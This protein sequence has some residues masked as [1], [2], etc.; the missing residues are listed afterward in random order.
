MDPTPPSSLSSSFP[1]R[2]TPSSSTLWAHLIRNDSPLRPS[3]S[4]VSSAMQSMP[5][6]PL[7]K[8]GTSMR[9]L[10]LDTQTNFEN[11]SG[12]VDKLIDCVENA[13]SEVEYMKAMMQAERENAASEMIDLVNRCQRE[14]QKSIK[15]PAQGAQ[16]QSLHSD[17]LA[18]MELVCSRLESIDESHKANNK[19]LHTQA[20][21]ISQLQDQYSALATTVL[22]VLPTLEGLKTT[23]GGI[24]T[25]MEHLFTTID[26]SGARITES[27]HR[28]IPDTI[29]QGV[30]STVLTS[31]SDTVRSSV[32]S[33]VRSTIQDAVRSTIPDAARLSIVDSIAS[34]LPQAVSSSVSGASAK[35]TKDLSTTLRASIADTLRTALAANTKD[36]SKLIRATV[37]DVISTTLPDVVRTVVPDVVRGVGDQV[38]KDSSAYRDS[39]R[40]IL[41]QDRRILDQA[42]CD[43]LR[44]TAT[45]VLRDIPDTIRN[46]LNER[47]L[48]ALATSVNTSF[49]A[50]SVNT[51]SLATTSEHRC[52]P[53]KRRLD[54]EN[55]LPRKRPRKTLSGPA[56]GQDFV[57]PPRPSTSRGPA[58]LPSEQ[59]GRLSLDGPTR[60]PLEG[61]ARPSYKP[62]GRLTFRRPSS[63][64]AA[65]E[66]S[67]TLRPRPPSASQ[68]ERSATS[69]LRGQVFKRFS[70]R[71][72][73]G[74]PERRSSAY[75]QSSVPRR[76]LAE[77]FPNEASILRSS[78][79]GV[80]S[81]PLGVSRSSPSGSSSSFADRT[82]IQRR[83]RSPPR[84]QTQQS[85]GSL[86]QWSQG[87]Q[88][89]QS[90]DLHAGSS[91]YS[92]VRP[93]EDTKVGTDGAFVDDEMD[94]TRQDAQD[95]IAED[96][97]VDAEDDVDAE[98][99][100]VSPEEWDFFASTEAYL[101]TLTED[102]HDPT[103]DELDVPSSD[104]RTLP[105]TEDR[106]A[107]SSD[108]R[109]VHSSDD[110]EVPSSDDCIP[111]TEDYQSA[112]GEK[113]QF[114]SSSPPSSPS[115]DFVSSSSP[116]VGSSSPSPNF[117]SPPSPLS[118]A[119]SMRSQAGRKE[120]DTSFA[121]LVERDRDTRTLDS[122]QDARAV[123]SDQDTRTVAAMIEDTLS[124]PA[125]ASLRDVDDLYTPDSS[126]VVSGC[127]SSGT[128]GRGTAG[129]GRGRTPLRALP[130]STRVLRSMSPAV[131]LT[132]ARGTATPTRGMVTPTPKGKGKLGMH[133]PFTAT[134][135]TRASARATPEKLVAGLP[136]RL[137]G[138]L[139]VVQRRF[140]TPAAVT[141]ASVT[142]AQ[143]STMPQRFVVPSRVAA[144]GQRLAMPAPPMVPMLR[145]AGVV[146]ETGLPSETVMPL[147]AT[148]TTNALA[149]TSPSTFRGAILGASTVPPG[150]TRA[151]S[152]V[153]NDNRAHSVAPSNARAQS[154]APGNNMF[155]RQGRRFIP[156]DDSDD[157]IVD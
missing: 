151:Q 41:D 30:S 75:S 82:I 155:Y 150:N 35:M 15:E 135:L 66:Q 24:T 132:P 55:D 134:R 131:A 80:L 64:S 125:G 143:R 43:T 63:T 18:K 79:Q 142:P 51:S 157:E 37:R 126:S 16:L 145:E 48:A 44:S 100:V 85:Q 1:S 70:E 25:T 128:R 71:R 34:V 96:V 133:T 111:S 11:F 76:P 77:I 102:S 74:L 148:S 93:S 156:L 46:V 23:V 103:P 144:S 114:P 81:S 137:V 29:A 7:D 32:L 115:R 127:G 147:L 106:D 61:T 154:T 60:L 57:D 124:T 117:A 129:R 72:S 123:E 27:L 140:V 98:G 9:M 139:P 36:V 83:T 3:P 78:P 116:H 110:R 94:A 141:A 39:N 14:I 2:R 56:R 26:D 86:I 21:S 88:P 17:M 45:D 58:R 53:R 68:P 99:S 8:T 136:E 22:P 91:H 112:P 10:L 84:S 6:A 5:G 65:R 52:S 113:L 149:E 33:S 87:S 118:S 69:T 73:T 42:L 38:R 153:P 59:P 92:T 119:A 12:R 54:A 4:T 89:R 28:T 122:D 121:T 101:S 130:L 40:Q 13:K 97:G 62:T 105:M 107:L 50:T 109:E 138:D 95:D 49:L 120:A 20:Q 31:V 19:L 152:V 146:P 67:A 108:G 90:Q 104:D 47:L